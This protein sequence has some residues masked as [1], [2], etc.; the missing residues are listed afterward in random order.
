[1]VDRNCR[2]RH[3][4]DGAVC[5]DERP[6]DHL[7]PAQGRPAEEAARCGTGMPA[8]WCRASPKIG[9]REVAAELLLAHAARTGALR[10]GL[11]LIGEMGFAGREFEDLVTASLGLR[12]IRPDRRSEAPVTDSSA[13][14]G[15]GPAMNRISQRH[16]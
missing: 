8:T 2:P 11:A 16:R 12:L 15:D 1:M 6:C 4:P 14:S 13:G 10:P 9:K 7:W 5:A 3:S